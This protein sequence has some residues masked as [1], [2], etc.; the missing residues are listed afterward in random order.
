MR[1]FRLLKAGQDTLRN[2][3]GDTSSRGDSPG[4]SVIRSGTK[5]G[6]ELTRILV[7]DDD[8]STRFVI[9]LILEKAGFEI[10]EARHGEEALDMIRP[11]PLPDIVSTDL[12][13]PFV[14][15]IDL[16]RR[17]RAEQR[18]AKIPIVVV[19][20]NPE[21]AR[22][23]QIEGLVNAIIRKP[24]DATKLVECIRAA[25]GQPKGGGIAS[26]PT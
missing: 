5:V 8:P 24:F 12:M 16:I 10:A 25:A 18:T 17:L 3:Q 14:N 1:W 2:N 23:L 19:S 11:G 4:A 26:E 6:G 20:G 21:A 15:G 7:V 22:E 13:M 9:K